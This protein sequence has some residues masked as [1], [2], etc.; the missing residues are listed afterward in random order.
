MVQVSD[1]DAYFKP[2][3]IFQQ[4]LMEYISSGELKTNNK[5]Q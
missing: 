5:L 4:F 1:K 3:Y 2:E